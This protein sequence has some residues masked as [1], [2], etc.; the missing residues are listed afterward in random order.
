[1]LAAAVATADERGHDGVSS[2]HLLAG[3]ALSPDEIV[4]ELLDEWGLVTDDLLTQIDLAVAEAVGD[5][6]GATPGSA[7]EG[8]PPAKGAMPASDG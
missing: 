6:E 7:S 3:L 8:A 5:D 2:L 1:M 4:T